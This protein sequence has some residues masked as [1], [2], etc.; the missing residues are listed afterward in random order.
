[1][2]LALS[3]VRRIARLARI[4]IT[5]QEEES[6]RKELSSVLD[7]VAELERVDITGVMPHTS[8][9]DRDTVMRP[10][11]LVDTS[12]EGGADDLMAQ[13]PDVRDRWVRVKNVFSRPTD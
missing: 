12:L 2:A 5:K 11:E 7:F 8:G 13:V 6:L 1:M 3:E 4:S 9:T 10:D